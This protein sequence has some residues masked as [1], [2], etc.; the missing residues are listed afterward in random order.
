MITLRTIGKIM[1]TNVS[2]FLLEDTISSSTGT[3]ATHDSLEIALC[4]EV[5]IGRIT[6]IPETILLIILHARRVLG[7][8]N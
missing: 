6:I 7:E 5:H 8:C 2:R 1:T 3:E 4:F